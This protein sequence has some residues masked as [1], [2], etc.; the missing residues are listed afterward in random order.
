MKNWWIVAVVARA[1]DAGVEGV[2]AAVFAVGRRD[3]LGMDNQSF[4][5]IFGYNL[6]LAGALC[7]GFDGLAGSDNRA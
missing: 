7:S 3:Q 1:G 6:V 4:A 2:A 5:A